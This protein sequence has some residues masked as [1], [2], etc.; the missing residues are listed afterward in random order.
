ETSAAPAEPVAGPI[1]R[2]R[3]H[4]HRISPGHRLHPPRRP[5]PPP[6][7]APPPHPAR[8][9]H[10]RLRPLI[11]RPVQVPVPPQHRQHHVG[12]PFPQP[13]HQPPRLRLRP[14]R[15]INRHRPRHLQ[16]R[17]R[18]HRIPDEPSPRCALLSRGL[19]PRVEQSR[20]QQRLL[21]SHVA[22]GLLPRD[23]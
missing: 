14:H 3:R 11:G 8:P 23:G 18:Q 19:G 15:V 20:A 16:L 1:H 6:P 12:P 13:V 10:H 17:Q 5:P 2:Q 21:R 22:H 4:Q 7:P 9:R